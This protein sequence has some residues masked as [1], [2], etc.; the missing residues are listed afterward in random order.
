MKKGF[1]YVALGHIHKYMIFGDENI[2]Y[3]GSMINTSFKE[4]KTGMIIGEFENYSIVRMNTNHQNGYNVNEG[5]K[6]RIEHIN[7]DP[8]KYETL[9]MNISDISSKEEL[10]TKIN[11]LEID[12]NNFYKLVFKGKKDFL[13]NEKYVLDNI[14]WNN[15][16]RIEDE[17]ERDIDIEEIS[18]ENTLRG[19]FVK[20]ILEK[21]SKATNTTEKE[22][23]DNAI[24][25]VLTEMRESYENR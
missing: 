5:T 18:K 25:L 2:V 22:K 17:T 23:L 13:I 20:K 11:Y 10:V 8:I 12:K 4:G 7:L 6:V 1:D 21:K 3:P 24:E 15:I 19:I 16:L 9:Y 14:Q